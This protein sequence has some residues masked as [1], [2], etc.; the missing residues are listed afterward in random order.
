MKRL[1]KSIWAGWLALIFTGVIFLS[2]EAFKVSYI[3]GIGFLA[4]LG[5]GISTRLVWD[6]NRNG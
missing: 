1:E 4:L 2:W 6:R 3:L 5:I